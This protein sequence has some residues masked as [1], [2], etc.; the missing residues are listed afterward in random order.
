V[1][2]PLSAV[3]DALGMSTDRWRDLP[4][5]LVDLASLTPTQATG[6]LWGRFSSASGDPCIHV[7][8]ILGVRLVQDGHHRRAKA[9]RRGETQIAARVL[10][11]SIRGVA[12]EA[13]A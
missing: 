6:D 1:E 2:V 5:E 4:A 12:S 13:A 10:R 8:E 3:T 7:V 11:V 9:L